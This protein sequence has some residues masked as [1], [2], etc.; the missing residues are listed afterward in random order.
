MKRFIKFSNLKEE[1]V[2]LLQTDLLKQLREQCNLRMQLKL[3]QLK[4]V[5]MLR[6]IRRNVA[7][8]KNGLSAK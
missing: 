7:S 4:K 6:K 8:I 3:G 5:H 2:T 1:N